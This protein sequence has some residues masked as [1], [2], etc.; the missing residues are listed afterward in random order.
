MFNIQLLQF[1]CQS[2][3]YDENALRNCFITNRPFMETKI[4][5]DQILKHEYQAWAQ[6]ICILIA[7]GNDVFGWL[8]EN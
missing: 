3:I 5:G 8:H 6:Y 7:V 2:E 1:R 4:Y